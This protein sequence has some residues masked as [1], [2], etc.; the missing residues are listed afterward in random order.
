[1]GGFDRLPGWVTFFLGGWVAWAAFTAVASAQTAA[2]NAD[3]RGL[4][5]TGD[6][7]A[8]TAW[9]DQ[10]PVAVQRPD[11]QGMQPIHWAAFFGKR[12]V[13]ELLVARGA[14]L[15]AGC[16]L[17]TPLHVAVFG[18]QVETVRWLVSRGID[19]NA[20]AGE[21]VP[22]LG[23][24]IRQENL[25][26]VEALLALGASPRTADPMGNS[27]LLLAVSAGFEPAVRLLLDKGA[28][29]S[30][31][32]SRGRTPLDVA[33]RENL[34]A[35]VAL[36]EARGAKSGPTPPAPKGPYL[37]QAL[38]GAIP[39]LFA[40]DF[41]STEKR[42]LNASFSPDGRELYF[43]RERAP[44]RTTILV[45]RREGD[46]WSA[47]AAAPFSSGNASEVDVFITLDGRE[48]YFCS[49]RPDP[50]APAAGKPPDA[51]SAPNSD[52]WVASREGGGWGEP[53]SLGRPVNSDADDYYPTLAR[54]GTMYFS[55]NRPGGLGA[56]DIYRSRPDGQGRWSTPENLGAPVNTPGREFDPFI[57]PDGGWL[58]FAS[59]RPGGCGAA[60]LYV[61][62]L[63]P[64]GTWGEPKNLGPPVNTA[65]SEYTPLL[66]P[67]GRCLF[68][69]RGRFGDDIYWV[70]AKVIQALS[71]R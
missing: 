5:R 68:F 64:D 8:V 51:S 44:R 34:G 49:T 43:A 22:P 13:I 16:R 37:G 52:I 25:A 54:D 7:A 56:N 36:L 45:A 9:L 38:P 1:M 24:A 58:A 47:P 40:P 62:F 35:I 28:D 30:Q 12:E 39:A 3:V 2:P 17:G 41:V 55:S 6:P 15:R 19:P 60:D 63:Q 67:D 57:A 11:A 70:D 26:M 23:I 32:N 53:R 21:V 61:S 42:E 50:A 14:D 27:P 65:D 18:N 59:E 29:T 46:E 69:T 66:S 31:A 20:P 71:G 33:R 10:D 4:L 48:A